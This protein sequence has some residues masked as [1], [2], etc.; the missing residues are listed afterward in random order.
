[1][2]SDPRLPSHSVDHPERRTTDRPT[3]EDLA[4]RLD[5]VETQLEEHVHPELVHIAEA[6]W[7]PERPQ[8]EGGGR[9]GAAGMVYRLEKIEAHAASVDARLAE[10]TGRPVSLSPRDRAMLW[11]AAIGAIGA[12]VAA[13]AQGAVG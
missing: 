10:L 6:L 11:A 9:D 3:H 13:I 1:M 4:A 2:R 12:V 8:V 5:R 7:G